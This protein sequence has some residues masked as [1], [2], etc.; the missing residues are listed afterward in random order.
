VKTAGRVLLIAAAVFAAAGTAT[1]FVARSKFDSAK[2][3]GCPNASDCGDLARS[4][5]TTNRLS[6][7]MYVG[8]VA[9]GAA[10]GLMLLLAP[11]A[12]S[13]AVHV[14]VGARFTFQ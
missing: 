8:A 10:G 6:Q 7:A 12:E 2:E 14:A 9:T 4:V 5:S 3:H 11:T 1:L 13:G